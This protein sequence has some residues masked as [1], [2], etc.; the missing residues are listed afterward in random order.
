MEEH[1]ARVAP[2]LRVRE[3]HEAVA[4]QR[5][6]GV[7]RVAVRPH[8][9]VA[10]GRAAPRRELVRHLAE[11][12]EHAEDEARVLAAAVVA[13]RAVPLP[14]KKAAAGP[15]EDVERVEDHRRCGL[16]S[17]GAPRARSRCGVASLL[18][19]GTA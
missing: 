7:Q 19:S 1:R 9:D 3:E 14:I 13:P 18:L 10:V 17:A 4:R 12:V 2:E 16:L 5:L 15:V 6:E 8:R 11:R